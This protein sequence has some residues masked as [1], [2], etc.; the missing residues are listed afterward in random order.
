MSGGELLGGERCSGGL[1][2]ESLC[3]GG[4]RDQ[5]MKGLGDRLRARNVIP[6]AVRVL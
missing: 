6:K 1:S 4:L 2:W 5:L 3:Q